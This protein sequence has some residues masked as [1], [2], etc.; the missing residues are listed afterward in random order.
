MR[1][2]AERNT[3]PDSP[4]TGKT[5]ASNVAHN[6]YILVLRKSKADHWKGWIEE[7]NEKDVW[8]ARKYA[9]NPLSDGARSHIPT[10]V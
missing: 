6:T 3:G 4:Q 10:L 1:S 8:T 5:H 9:K 2:K 7:A